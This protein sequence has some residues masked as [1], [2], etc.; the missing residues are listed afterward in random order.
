[1]MA[2][3][4]ATKPKVARDPMTALAASPICDG[5]DDRFGD[6]GGGVVVVE[7]NCMS[8]TGILHIVGQP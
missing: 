6:F 3:I 5:F 8:R 1:M 4:A 2:M 7:L